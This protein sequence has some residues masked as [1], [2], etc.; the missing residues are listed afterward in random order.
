MLELEEK[1][2]QIKR[3]Q[4]II[5]HQ[6]ELFL[7]QSEDTQRDG[8]RR[9]E[10]IKADYE[11][12]INRNYKLIDELIEEKKVL[13]TKCEEFLEELKTVTK[14]TNEKIKALEE[15]LVSRR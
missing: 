12:T 8:D 6:R 3:L 2:G 4:R 7:R 11:C 9:I 5:E 14:K 15:R 10:S 13:H 1:K